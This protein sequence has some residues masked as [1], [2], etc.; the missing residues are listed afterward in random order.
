MS[1]IFVQDVC[2]TPLERKEWAFDLTDRVARKWKPRAFYTNG[3]RIRPQ[4]GE[5]GLEYEAGGDGQSGTREPRWPLT[6][7][8]TIVDGSITW[9]ARAISNASL[10][11]TISSVDWDGAG[12]T[13]TQEQISNTGG[14]QKISAKV[15]GGAVGDEHLVTA[16][17]TFNDAP[18][19]TI[20]KFGLRVAIHAAE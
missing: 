8:Q 10:R 12:L 14:S 13:V 5:T 20:E 11:R 2:K 15:S 16:V 7:G 3:L 17:V 19:P 9:T 6:I 1:C 18:D 4:R